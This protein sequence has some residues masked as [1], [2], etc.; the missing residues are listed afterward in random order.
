MVESDTAPAPPPAYAATGR[1]WAATADALLVFAPALAL[2]KAVPPNLFPFASTDV[3]SA[4]TRAGV[5]PLLNYAQFALCAAIVWIAFAFGYRRSRSIIEWVAGAVHDRL[6]I[7]RAVRFATWAVGV[8][9]LVVY[10]VN[11][12]TS[13]IALPLTDLFHE[14]EYLGFV[15]V[16]D[17]HAPAIA[18]TFTV[19]GPGVDLL[20][21]YAAT[22]V[23]LDDRGIVV[24]RSAYATLRFLAVVAAFW[25]T[26]M[27]ATLALPAASILARFVLAFTSFAILVTALQAGA[28]PDELALHKTLNVRDLMFLVQIATAL[29]F[30]H[31][32]RSGRGAWTA[33]ALAVACGALLPLG[34]IY[35][36]DRGLY[37]VA[38]AGFLSIVI[39][40]CGKEWARR[41]FPGL[42]AG[43]AVATATAWV[44]I[45]NDGIAAL[46]DQL[47]FWIRHGRAIWAYS[48]IATSGNTWAGFLLAG[49]FL[50][51]A[52]AAARF[53]EALH[54]SG[55]LAEAT[56]RE[57]PS[58]VLV[59]AAIASVRMAVERGDPGHIAWGTTAAW[60][61]LSVYAGKFVVAAFTPSRPGDPSPIAA[62]GHVSSRK[63]VIV[64]VAA[65][66]GF[67]CQLLDPWSAI[68]TLYRGRGISLQTSDRSILS[69]DQMEVI[70]AMKAPMRDSRCFYT[71]TN[72]SAWYYLLGKES[73]SRFYQVTNARPTTAQQEVVAALEDKRPSHILFSSTGWSNRIDGISV[74]N[75]NPLVARYVITHYVPERDIAGSWF[76]RR[77][78]ALPTYADSVVGAIV[79]AP[80]EGSRSWDLPVNGTWRKE[81]LAS[82]AQGLLVTVGDEN[83]PVW[84]GRLESDDAAHG[85]WSAV[86]PTA[87]LTPGKH[88]VR[89]WA[90]QD[91]GAP[92]P[93]LGE[94]PDLQIR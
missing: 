45:G 57:L 42:V 86:L 5:E 82:S 53:R 63:I 83:T 16:F 41:W 26:A 35:C 3:V 15:P 12:G 55:R 68:T 69:R 81:G 90:I 43:A 79:D 38:F 19:H 50:A 93:L 84:A 39:A 29:A 85:R 6:E 76:W 73:C 37:G 71:L 4:T 61:L 67:N 25:A 31:A 62:D 13:A 59:A 1:V 54:A 89:I 66:L 77:A 27:L 78:R 36:F 2:V 46:Q 17:A 30:V 47:A 58:L 65:L 92:M 70:A 56:R 33:E 24:V 72:E 7:S 48:G 49:G 75:A 87:G 74:F 18:T 60:M 28:W 64:A 21:G 80:S 94:I 11:V 23:G 10:L 9:G 32:Q 44:A 8:C 88:R 52:L 22:T 14:G 40:I 91:E 51:M 20:P 34:M